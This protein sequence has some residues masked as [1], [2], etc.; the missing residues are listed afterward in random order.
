MLLLMVFGAIS[1]ESHTVFDIPHNMDIA[2]NPPISSYDL[3]LPLVGG[4]ICKDAEHCKTG[5]NSEN[6]TLTPDCAGT[7]SLP[8][9]D[10]NK[11]LLYL[12]LAR[13]IFNYYCYQP[14]ASETPIFLSQETQ[15]YDARPILPD[16]PD[17][18][19][20]HSLVPDFYNY[21]YASLKNSSLHCLGTI[22]TLDRQT[23]V[24]ISDPDTLDIQTIEVGQ[25]ESIPTP[26][27]R[28]F[29]ANWAKITSKD[30]AWQYYRVKTY[31]GAPPT[32]CAGQEKAIELHYAA[33]YW[34]YR[35]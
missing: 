21:D 33:E 22:S 5:Q 2:D 18:D 27:D 29:D 7:N 32:S 30:E 16:I 34:F 3:E 28:E 14:D 1:I 13:G 20:F 8:P 9:P 25:I 17:E 15:L 4:I 23:V 19:A 35:R 12:A 6:Q 31:Y 26:D 24:V 10:A 11:G